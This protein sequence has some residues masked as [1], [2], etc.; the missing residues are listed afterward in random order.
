MRKESAAQLEKSNLFCEVKK[1][2]LK[3]L[4][5]LAKAKEVEASKL[6]R[7]YKYLTSADGKTKTLTKC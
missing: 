1:E 2:K 7:G 5:A 4:N 6:K 3:A